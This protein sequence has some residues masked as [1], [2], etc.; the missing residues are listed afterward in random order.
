MDI[1]ASGEIHPKWK[2]LAPYSICLAFDAD[3]REFTVTEQTNTQY[4]KLILF[5]RIVTAAPTASAPFYL[6]A[7]PF[8]SSLLPPLA[9]KLE[10][11]LFSPLFKVEKETILPAITLT[12]ALQQS[13]IRYVDWFKTDSQGTDLRLFR[14]LPPAALGTVKAAELE[15][16]IIDAYEGE[17]KLYT[18]LQEM[19]AAG[20]WLSAMVVKGTQR[21]HHKYQAQ[22][23]SFASERIIRRS[24]C[25]TELTWLREATFTTERDALLLLVFALLEKQWGF[26]L[27]VIDKAGALSENPVFAESRKAVERQLNFEKRILPLT[28]LRKKISKLLAPLHAKFL[29]I[30]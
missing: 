26:A 17:D 25:W 11:W 16:G 9:A 2:I 10:P 12:A 7:S 6:T 21:L 20:F 15:P 14:S 8:C 23:G 27:E 19:P 28:I 3:D 24:P 22:W 4:K 29:Y 1:G 30:I 13:G 18:I 5:N